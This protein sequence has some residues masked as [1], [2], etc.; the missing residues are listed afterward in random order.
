MLTR[1]ALLIT[2]G[3]SVVVVGA[4]A[5]AINTTQLGRTA[6][7]PWLAIQQTFSDARLNVLSH[8]ILAPSPHNR[9]PWRVRLDED[10]ETFSLFVDRERLLPKTDP[11]NRQIVV[12]LGAFIETASIAATAF[13]YSLEVQPFPDGENAEALDDRVVAHLRLHRE[14]GRASDPLFTSIPARRTN[15]LPFDRERPVTIDSLRQMQ[16]L[17]G[18][19]EAR[20]GADS[21]SAG[22]AALK[23]LCQQAWHVESTTAETH[24]ESVR[25]T[26]IGAAEIADNPDGISIGGV[27]PSALGK[28][29]I[30]TRETLLDTESTAFSGMVDFY[31]QAIESAS[32]FA[33]ITSA[34]NSRQSQLRA[35]ADWLRLHLAATQLGIAFHP[36]SQALQEFEEMAVHYRDIHEMLGVSSPAVVQGLFRLGYAD[37]PDPA[38]RWALESRIETL[39]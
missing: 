20:F 26:R 12:G 39:G 31:N 17:A 38:P 13:G 11:Y 16:S 35:G 28:V 22:V 18:I 8:A 27:L 23:A 7:S 6:R 3:A 33:W 10:A 2:G 30:L 21:S 4:A 34:D 36:L 5:T 37:A 19:S 32:A 25:L 15:R 9:Q 29:G 1:R 14:S 24:A